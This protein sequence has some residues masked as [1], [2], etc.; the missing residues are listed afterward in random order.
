MF[1]FMHTKM[2]PIDVTTVLLNVLQLAMTPFT[3]S[4]PHFNGYAVEVWTMVSNFL[5]YFIMDVITQCWDWN[6]TTSVKGAP[7]VVAAISVCDAELGHLSY[8]NPSVDWTG[9]FSTSSMLSVAQI[10]GKN[11]TKFDGS[12]P[13]W[14]IMGV[15]RHIMKQSVCQYRPGQWVTYVNHAKCSPIGQ[16]FVDTH[17]EK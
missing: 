9:I 11:V 15:P 10:I 8:T 17:M 2:T 4:F 7:A 16:Y 3:H 5:P 13:F 6:Q 1:V 14:D 12:S